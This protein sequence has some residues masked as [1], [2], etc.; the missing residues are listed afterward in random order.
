MD[1]GQFEALIEY[2]ECAIAEGVAQRI[3]ED[4]GSESASTRDAKDNLRDLLVK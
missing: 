3:D 4:S 1:E 2:I